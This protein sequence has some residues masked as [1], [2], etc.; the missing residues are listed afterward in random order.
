MQI[1]YKIIK[2]RQGNP[3]KIKKKKLK[4]INL[5]VNLATTLKKIIGIDF[6]IAFWLHIPN[7]LYPKDHRTTKKRNHKEIFYCTQSSYR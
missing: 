7:G 6:E 4:R 2:Q 3:L 5:T 1:G